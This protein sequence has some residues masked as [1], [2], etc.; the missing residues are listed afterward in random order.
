MKKRVLC[1][2]RKYPPSVG[3]M[4]KFCADLYG[5]LGQQEDIE[6]KVIALGKSQKHLVWFFPYCVFYLIFN[7]RKWDVIL[8]SDALFAGAAFVAKI[9]S[10]KTVLITDIHGLD[11]LYPNKLYQWYMKR[12]LNKFDVYVCNSKNTEQLLHSRNIRNT[13]IIHRGVDVHKFDGIKRDRERF[14][15]KYQI[16]AEQTVVI[17]V[18]RLVK[19]KGVEWFIRNVMSDLDDDIVYMIAGAGD[20]YDV[21]K[22]A[23]EENKLQDRVKLLGKIAERDLNEL[24]V[25]ADAFVMPNIKVDGDVEGFGIVAIEAASAGLIV[26]ASDVDGISDAVVDNV[27]GYLVQSEDVAGFTQMIHLI[28]NKNAELS[29]EKIR[30][31]TIE[32]Y[33]MDNITRKYLEVI[34]K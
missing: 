15:K 24:Y 21:I 17:T 29:P 13:V 20:Q 32:E 16:A 28:K 5:E 22:R 8:F 2:T 3:G 31:Y 10:P 30:E 14:A 12:F 11:I 25:N 7:A 34:R 26:V 23:I 27:N 1:M 19:R 4:E 18:G 9:F 6:R 33:S